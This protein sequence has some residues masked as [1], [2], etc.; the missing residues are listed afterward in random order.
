M[1]A[2]IKNSYTKKFP[3][4]RFIGKRYTDEDRINGSF[5]AKWGEWSQKDMF[6]PLEK[7]KV[8]SENE[9]TYYGAMR[10]VNGRFEYWIG[11]FCNAGATAPEGYDFI[12]IKP[13]TF[14]VFWLYGSEQNGEIYGIDNHNMCL[15][16]MKQQGLV[17]SDDDWC[18]EGYVC[19]RYTT[20]DEKGNVILDYGIAV[21]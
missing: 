20:P 15:D 8:T 21:K 2:K 13:L 9:E 18:F 11:M 5:G 1:T 7:L 10:I 4:T 14:A 17:H 6:A 19:P 16:E 12:D 3:E